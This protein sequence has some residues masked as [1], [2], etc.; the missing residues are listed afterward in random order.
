MLLLNL[1]LLYY[2]FRNNTSIITTP[3]YYFFFFSSYTFNII[4]F[5]NIKRYCILFTTNLKKTIIMVKTTKVTNSP[6]NNFLFSNIFFTSLFLYLIIKLNSWN[7]YM[8]NVIVKNNTLKNTIIQIL[9]FYHIIYNK[10]LL[11]KKLK[12]IKYIKASC[13]LFIESPHISCYNMKY[14][15]NEYIFLYL[16][17]N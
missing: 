17:L 13:I 1:Q 10:A 8:P 7:V 12:N 4:S 16:I 2:H 14:F 11:S 5:I 15:F 6:N 3:Y 9:F